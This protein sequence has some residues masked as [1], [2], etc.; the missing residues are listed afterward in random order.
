MFSVDAVLA[1]EM[2]THARLWI[3]TAHYKEEDPSGEERWPTN[4]LKFILL[5]FNF[6]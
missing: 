5:N 1:L 4:T 6:I 3:S 2:F